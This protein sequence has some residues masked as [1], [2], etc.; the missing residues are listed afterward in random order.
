MGYLKPDE[1]TSYNIRDLSGEF[2]RTGVPTDSWSFLHSIYYAFRNYRHL[3]SK[4]RAEFIQSKRR[5]IRDNIT[6]EKWIEW[7]NGSICFLRMTE[8]MRNNTP[9]LHQELLPE[10]MMYSIL[11]CLITES[12]LE[13]QIIP[14]WIEECSAIEEPFDTI[15]FL[16]RMKQVWF[17]LFLERITQSIIQ[18]E[19]AHTPPPNLMT[20][21][22]RLKVSHKLAHL[23]Y[24]I[25]DKVI[26][27]SFEEFKHSVMQDTSLDQMYI[28][29]LLEPL[30][31][32]CNLFILDA[33]TM[34]VIDMVGPFVDEN[35]T[36]IL[37]SFDRQH[38]EPLGKIMRMEDGTKTVSRLFSMEDDIV[39]HLEQDIVSD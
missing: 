1:N 30:Q 27:R 6:L 21:E 28:S 34:E 12:V 15:V 29:D 5:I 13:D 11:F 25:L 23:S 38:Y 36:I 17:Q 8:W 16:N 7:Q 3:D 33:D 10:N 32:G 24:D 35:P 18:L 26:E 20:R 14:K 4:G 19:R 39:H 2:I 37:L 31:I 22:E 9:V